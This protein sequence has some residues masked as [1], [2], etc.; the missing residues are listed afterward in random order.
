MTDG[1]LDDALAT[2]CFWIVALAIVIALL[3]VTV[4]LGVRFGLWWKAAYP[5]LA[6]ILDTCF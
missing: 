1:N 6:K 2:G 4:A 3:A 5:C